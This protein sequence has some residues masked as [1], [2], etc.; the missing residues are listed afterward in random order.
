VDTVWLLMDPVV[1]CRL[2][3]DRGWSADRY[4]RW[5]ADTVRRLLLAAG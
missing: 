2:T 5:F 4:E 3:E 1:F